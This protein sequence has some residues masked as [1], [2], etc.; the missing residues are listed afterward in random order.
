M[1]SGWAARGQNRV[2]ACGR[3]TGRADSHVAR[4]VCGLGA[5]DLRARSC[6]G[7]E[8]VG[9]WAGGTARTAWRGCARCSGRRDIAVRRRFQRD[10]FDLGHFDQVFLPKLEPKCIEG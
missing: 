5:R 3:D 6:L 9:A 8:H 7:K 10:R 4:A 2:H 1:G